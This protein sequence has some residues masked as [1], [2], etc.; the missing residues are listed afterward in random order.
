MV[1]IEPLRNICC[2]CFTPSVLIGEV[3][4]NEKMEEKCTSHG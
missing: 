1:P 2:T 4:Q 3:G